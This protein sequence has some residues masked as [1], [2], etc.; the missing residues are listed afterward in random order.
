MVWG[1][2]P[3]YMGNSFYRS[4]D[5]LHSS[6]RVSVGRGAGL[7]CSGNFCQCCFVLMASVGYWVCLDDLGNFLQ[8]SDTEP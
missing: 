1:W 8:L 4:M 6:I 5:L 2:I 3:D 7:A